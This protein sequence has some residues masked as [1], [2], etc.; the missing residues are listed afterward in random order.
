MNTDN[1]LP[2]GWTEATPGGMATNRCPERGGII[3]KN[4]AGLGWFVIFNADIPAIEGLPSREAAFA[5]LAK[6]TGE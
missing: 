2:A 4:T 3:D 1:T 6:A 5:A